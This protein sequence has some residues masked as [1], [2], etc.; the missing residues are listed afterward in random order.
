MQEITH[1]RV[2]LNSEANIVLFEDPT[3][4]LGYGNQ[5]RDFEA[6][7]GRSWFSNFINHDDYDQVKHVFSQLFDPQVRNTTWR[8]YQNLVIKQEGE[9][10]AFN[11]ANHMIEHNEERFVE[12]FGF[13]TED[14]NFLNFQFPDETHSKSLDH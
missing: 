3:N 13:T 12:S 10:Q 8:S 2:V 6:L 1:F 4:L 9:Q 7:H 14:M 11:F 5:K